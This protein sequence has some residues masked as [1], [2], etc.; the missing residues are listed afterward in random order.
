MLH[1]QDIW[2]IARFEVVRHLRSRHAIAAGLLLIL[3]CGFGAYELV[4]F[5]DKLA[6]LDR[7]LG[8][9][10]DM[11]AGMVE[12][13]TDLPVVGV[14]GLLRQHPPVLVA[15]FALVM[16]LMPLLSIIL[17]YDQTA[18]DIETR[19]VRY[20]LFRSDRISIFLGKA[21]GA[22]LII[23]IAVALVVLIFG[24]FLAVRTDAL[25][26]MKGV[27][28]LGRIW[29]TA[30]LYAVPFVALLGLSSALFGRARR[31]LTVAFLYWFGV[32]TLS[33]LLSLANEGFEHLR[34][35]FPSVGR[36]DLLLDDPGDLRGTVLYLVAFTLVAGLLGLWRFRSRDL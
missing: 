26:G 18:T 22:Q 24:V 17:A 16:F 28:Y 8:P 10:L 32:A 4:Q 9:A 15:L 12:G 31:S 25:E 13:L 14:R 34:Y 3:F 19:H 29:V 5:A 20:L 2:V 6:E 11:I 30:V 33:G 27:A 7:D 35:L 36:F 21:L 1:S 23:S